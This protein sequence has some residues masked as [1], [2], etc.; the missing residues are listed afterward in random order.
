ML[1]YIKWKYKH[2]KKTGCTFVSDLMSAEEALMI[3]DDLEKTGRAG[4]LEF[5]DERD[6]T[7]M[8]K[9]LK[10]Y[11]EKAIEEPD[12]ICLYFD[13]GFRKE[14]RLAGLGVAIYYDLGRKSYR[15]R[16]NRTLDQLTSNN[17]AE[18][19]A[20]YEGLLRLEELGVHHRR[21]VFRGDSQVVLNQLKG[22][23]PC[24]DELFNRWLDRIEAKIKAMGIEP[25]YEQIDRKMN[26]EADSLASQALE[27]TEIFGTKELAER[28]GI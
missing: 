20:F 11:I 9:E 27:G 17:E 28:K 4:Q 1:V 2:P 23:W 16:A 13:G 19:A 10:K 21:C 6:S 7:W 8:K 15:L 25:V 14:D 24:F 18:Y 26:Q 5:F 22:E 12:R 3:A